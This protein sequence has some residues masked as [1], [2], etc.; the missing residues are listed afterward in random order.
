MYW[1]IHFWNVRINFCT[2]ESTSALQDQF[3]CWKFNSCT[4]ETVSVLGNPF[5]HW[6]IDLCMGE[7]IISLR[8]RE[9]RSCKKSVC[10]G[11]KPVS[12]R[13]HSRVGRF[14]RSR[15]SQGIRMHVAWRIWVRFDMHLSDCS[16]LWPW[17]QDR[18]QTRFHTRFQGAGF[19]AGF[20]AVS[21][22]VGFKAGFNP[23]K[24]TLYVDGFKTFMEG[25]FLKK[26]MISYMFNELIHFPR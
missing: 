11:F 15:V 26:D 16:E 17:F 9:P 23:P 19:K 4:G 1:R 21:R 8:T 22:R 20:K 18:F 5:L 12:K 2:G 7:S 6:G 10:F 25:R 3:L 24:N 14:H 13:F